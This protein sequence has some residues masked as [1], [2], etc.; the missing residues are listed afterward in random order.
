[1]IFENFKFYLTKSNFKKNK[2]LYYFLYTFIIIILTSIY[3]VIIIE[4]YDISTPNLDLRIEGLQFDY[5]DL[6][7]NIVIKQE[8]SQVSYWVID[9][10]I[11]IFI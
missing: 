6:V 1:M 2:F 11:Y 10:F 9:L 5:A 8:Y 7:K 4:K 3:T